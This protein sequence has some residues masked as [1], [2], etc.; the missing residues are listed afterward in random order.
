[1]R[2]WGLRKSDSGL[3]RVLGVEMCELEK[4]RRIGCIWLLYVN[5]LQYLGRE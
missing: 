1:M 4:W 5:H 3:Q 2:R